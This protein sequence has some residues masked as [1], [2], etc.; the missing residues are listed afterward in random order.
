MAEIF[1][2]HATADRPLIDEFVQLLEGGIGI[3]SSQI[4]CSSLETQGVPPGVDF[5]HYIRDT[6]KDSQLV[7]GIVSERFYSSPF[8]MCELGASWVLAKT[9]IPILVPPVTFQDLRGVLGGTQC[10]SIDR[11]EDLDTMHSVVAK[12]SSEASAVA[13]WNSRKSRFLEKLHAT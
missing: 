1:V 5:K 6:I 2:S 8:C 12:L 10:L 9:F 11:S 4:F 7:I 3:R 13:R